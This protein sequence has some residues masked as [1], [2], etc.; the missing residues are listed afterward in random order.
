MRSDGTVFLYTKEDEEEDN[1]IRNYISPG[2]ETWREKWQEIGRLIDRRTK[3]EDWAKTLT[4]EQIK[5]LLE[6]R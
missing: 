1:K 3:L 6:D 5:Q 4:K 2:F